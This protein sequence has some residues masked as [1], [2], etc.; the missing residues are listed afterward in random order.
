MSLT[1]LPAVRTLIWQLVAMFNMVII[2]I[3]SFFTF[4]FLI[5]GC[6]ILE[7]FFLKQDRKGV[8]AERYRLKNELERGKAEK[9]KISLGH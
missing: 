7:A 8:D 1:P 3:S 4:H 9:T 2:T 5:F 6:Y